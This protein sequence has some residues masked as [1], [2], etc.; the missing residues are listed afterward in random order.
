[1]FERSRGCVILANDNFF[2]NEDFVAVFDE[3]L[4]TTIVCK[5]GS[6]TVYSC[7]TIYDLFISESRGAIRGT[8]L[9]LTMLVVSINLQNLDCVS[10]LIWLRD[11]VSNLKVNNQKNNGTI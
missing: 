2:S 10:L 11:L 8:V 4:A 3:G 7:E 1:M 9:P 6:E 5:T